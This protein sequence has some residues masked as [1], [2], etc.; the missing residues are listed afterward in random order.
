MGA[1]VFDFVEFLAARFADSGK[2]GKE[3]WTEADFASFGMDQAIRGME[4]DAMTYSREDL[5]ECWR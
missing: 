2:D 4:D 1:E 3:E 5:R